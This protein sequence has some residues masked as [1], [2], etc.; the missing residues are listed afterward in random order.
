MSILS[1][2]KKL[3]TIGLKEEHS[4]NERIKIELCNQ[5]E[6]STPGVGTTFLI[7]LSD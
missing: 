5:L 1:L 7:E 4:F 6:E 3:L 2:V